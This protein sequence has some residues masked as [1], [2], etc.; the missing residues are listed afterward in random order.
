MLEAAVLTVLPAAVAFAAAMDICQTTVEDPP[1]P[2]R[3][4]GLIRADLFRTNSTA[5]DSELVNLQTAVLVDYGNAGNAPRANATLAALATKSAR[6]AS[7][8]GFMEVV[9][10]PSWQD[11]RVAPLRYD[12]P[13]CPSPSTDA[14]NSASL[15]LALRAPTNAV[16]IRFRHTFFAAEFPELAERLSPP[17]VAVGG[18]GDTVQ[19]ASISAGGGYTVSGTSVTR[20]VFDLSDWRRSAWVVPLGASGHPG[21][22]HYA[23]QSAAWAAVRCGS[24]RGGSMGRASRGTC[25]RGA[26]C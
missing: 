26:H 7:D 25:C 14:V 13:S 10:P 22:P 21:S 23:D 20:F 12:F 1:L 18:D 19:A 2:Q 17:P 4:W 24:G 6:D 9:G 16:G 8:P 5:S 3:R 15:Q 11:V